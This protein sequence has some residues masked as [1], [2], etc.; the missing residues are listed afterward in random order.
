MS[1]E[2][3]FQSNRFLGYISHINPQFCKVHFPSSTLLNKSIYSGEEFNGGLIGNF[4]V[5]ESEKCG[6][7]GRISEIDLPEKERL[8]LTEKSFRLL[9]FH[10]TARIEILFAFDYYTEQLIQSISSHP[11]IGSKVFACS[12]KFIEKFVSNVGIKN[13]NNLK[14]ELG[15]LTSNK[16]TA[17]TVSQQTLFNRHCA[18]VGTT[19]S[20]K[21]W[22]VAKLIEG[23]K[24]NQSKLILIDATG[25]YANQTKNT[26]SVILGGD[27]FFSYKEM[28][29]YD[30]CCLVKP[31]EGVQKPKLM[32]AIRSLRMLEVYHSLKSEEKSKGISRNFS[33]FIQ[34]DLLIKKSNKSIIHYE[35]FYT[36]YYDEIEQDNL[37]L[38]IQMLSKQILNECIY[39]AQKKDYSI[40]G[41]INQNDSNYSYSLISRTN[42]L[43]TS[44]MYN[45][46]FNFDNSS[47]GMNLINEVESFIC[48]DQNDTNILRIGF[49]KVSYDFQI[50]E[51]VSNIIGRYLLKK[52]REGFFKEEPIV[53]IIDEAHQFL[54]RD[55]NLES[56]SDIKLDAFD[57]IAKESRKNGL[58]LCL[59]TQMPRDIPVGT[60]SQI[61][62]FIV[63]RLINI[64]DKDAIRQACSAATN[65]L[66]SYLP[67]LGEGEAILIGVDINVPLILKV[68]SPNTPPD[69][70]TPEFRYK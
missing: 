45:S 70:N 63:H 51:V 27:T 56:Y 4:V 65:D 13:K 35:R 58:F 57:Q 5:V 43:L 64:Y 26:K 49:E 2:F 24:D 60:L 40:F 61:G 46:I 62:T 12:D 38:N 21:S 34:D 1:K 67:G 18:I 11:N 15:K 31:S 69:S 42:H 29:K 19:G 48:S 30:F 16:E 33:G 25:E 23:I 52:S 28:S 9:D 10:P 53:L 39:P 14:I 32:E 59:S 20:G 3:P 41:D 7:I 55:S 8:S 44:K 50:R 17:V 37:R 66:I 36:K 47:I 68:N 54:K 22:T 6:F